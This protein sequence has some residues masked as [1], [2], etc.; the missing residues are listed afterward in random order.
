MKLGNIL[1]HKR[2]SCYS[3]DLKILLIQ[4]LEESDRLCTGFIHL[5]I[6]TS[7]GLV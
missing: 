6:G 3:K 2:E 1:K 7:G 5:K 4:I